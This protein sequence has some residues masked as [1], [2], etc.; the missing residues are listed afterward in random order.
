VPSELRR[1]KLKLPTMSRRWNSDRGAVAVE[2]ALIFPILI[3]ILIGIVEY[4]SM[5]NSQ[6]LVTGA[7]RE[8][9]RS[10]S[11]TGSVAQAQAAAVASAAGLAPRLTSGNVTVSASSC[12]SGADVTVTVTYV[13]PFLTGF[14]G[15]SIPLTASE[16]RR[17][18]G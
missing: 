17:C 12:T 18:F 11:V 16:T 4:G 5:F 9:A 13:K 14:F 8:G 2:F 3:V 7:A 10:M 6:L 1:R 15:A